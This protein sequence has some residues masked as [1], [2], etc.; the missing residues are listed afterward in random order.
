MTSSD[1]AV[2]LVARTAAPAL[3][4]NV[5]VS[6]FANAVD[7]VMFSQDFSFMLTIG[8]STFVMRLMHLSYCTSVSE[9][10]LR[11]YSLL[12]SV[13]CWHTGT[14]GQA[15]RSRSSGL[16]LR[17]CKMQYNGIQPGRG[18]HAEDLIK[19]ATPRSV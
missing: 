1:I 15:I 3:L 6:I 19:V 13:R 16:I 8:L 10:F 5:A 14:G 12:V 17:L 4:C 2:Q 11:V 18:I 9:I 7:E